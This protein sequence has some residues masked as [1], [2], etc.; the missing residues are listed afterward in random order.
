VMDYEEYI[1]RE[2]DIRSKD[3]I[4]F[5]TEIFSKLDG[6]FK[7]DEIKELTEK[8]NLYLERKKDLPF[9]IIKKELERI[10]IELSWKSSKIEGNTYSLIDT[11]VLIK[12][13]KKAEGHGD[14]EA[15]M[16]LNHKKAIDYIFDNKDKFKVLSL[17]SIE[18]IHRILIDGLGV[19]HGM[20]SR[21][22]GITGT[23]YRPLDNQH[24]VR[25]ALENAVLEI[26]KAKDPW[27]KALIALIMISYIQP[28][29]DGNKRTSRI[30]ANA[31]FIAH[32]ICPL[33]LRNINETEYKKA[34]TIF[35]E[36]QNATYMKKLFLE[37]FDFS[38]K[39]Y[40]L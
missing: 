4:L 7:K 23:Q 25:E 30:I 17:R 11:E 14:G 2:P 35:Y 26:N 27:S 31:C 34:I 22:V 38:I 1:S 10:T 39:N 21:A 32:D 6:I 5:K 36:L 20:R 19:N 37:Q 3:A 33:S 16:I 18:D 24:Q 29:E 12:E 28:F 15:V 8:N 9:A 40:F 13:N